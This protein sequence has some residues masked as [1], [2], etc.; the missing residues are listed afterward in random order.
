[1]HKLRNYIFNISPRKLAIY[2]VLGPMVLFLAHTSIVIAFRTISKPETNQL[3]SILL[4]ILSL[5]L[6]VFVLLWLV[7]LRSVI[8]SVQETEIGLKRKWFKIAY[9]FLWIFILF[10]LIALVIESPIKNSNWSEHAY[11]IYASREFINFGGILIAYPIICH[12][13]ARATI[14]KRTNK[15]ASFIKAV[16]FT[17]LLIFGTVLGIPFMHKYFSKKTSTNSKIIIIYA[18]AF[19][20]CITIFIIGFIAAITGMI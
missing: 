5:F 13:A 20:I 18:I 17:L 19:G 15:T 6:G 14:A 10:N 4:G 11:L 3:A 16:P 9:A 8:Y 12:Y 7:W 1:M 2:L